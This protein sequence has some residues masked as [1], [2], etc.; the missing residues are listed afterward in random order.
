MAEVPE[1]VEAVA[2]SSEDITAA[3]RLARAEEVSDG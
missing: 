3:D 2:A 1:V